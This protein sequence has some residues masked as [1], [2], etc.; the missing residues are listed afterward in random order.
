[1]DATGEVLLLTKDTAT[2]K[3]VISALESEQGIAAVTVCRDMSS[4]VSRLERTSVPIVLVDI[5]SQP[6]RI[7]DDLEPIANRF[8]HTRFIVL[9]THVL[10]DLMFKAMQVGVR[11]VQTKNTIASELA[12]VLQRLIP[13]VSVQN[14]RL[15]AVLTIL[16]ASGGCGSTTLVVNLANELQLAAGVPVLM[17]DLDYSYGAVA[18][19][20]DLHGH[21]GIAEVLG[22]EG[23]IDAQLINT[24]AVRHSENLHALLSPASINFAEVKPLQTGKLAAALSACKQGY[25]YTVIDAPRVSMDVAATLAE[26][27]DVTLI[28]LQPTVKDIRVAKAMIT[29][30]IERG[31]PRNRI[32]PILNRSRTRRQMISFDEAQKALGGVSL[33]RLRNDYSNAI[34]GSNYGRLLS[35]A[36]PRSALRRDVAHLAER[37]SAVNGKHNGPLRLRKP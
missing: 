34:R 24:T 33:E 22:H 16:S 3:A 29:A 20:L 11:H 30:L 25:K 27:S 35:Q 31:I 15:G 12:G 9:S 5:D 37:I 1:M 32:R 14:G 19:Y 2:E 23:G 21:Y 4:L 8:I 28:V 7:L 13:D 6:M 18:T 26:A 10:S 17:V 36:A